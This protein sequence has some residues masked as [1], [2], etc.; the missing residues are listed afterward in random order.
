VA[1]VTPDRAFVL[2]LDPATYRRHALHTDDCAWVEKNCYIDIWIEALHALGCEPLAILPFVVAVDFEG[3]QWT[4]FKPQHAEL[5]EL[6]G[7]GVE[8]LYVW[9]PLID[10]ATEHLGA[11][12]MISTEADAFWLP[13]TAGT[14]YRRQHTKTTIVLNDLDRAQRRLGYFHNANYHVLEGEDFTRTFRLDALP[15]PTFLPLFAEIVRVDRVVRRSPSDLAARSIGLWRR[16]LDRAPSDDPIARF[17]ERTERELPR[18]AEA[19]LDAYH[20]WAFG[21]VRQLGAAFELGAQNLRWLAEQSQGGAAFEE[22][23]RAFSAVSAAAKAFVL[24]AARAVNARRKLDA[25]QLFDAMSSERGAGLAILR[26]HLGGA[27]DGA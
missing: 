6:Y 25:A 24:K 20:A 9:R 17:R 13:D 27:E 23:A 19:G 2:D 21:T 4:F 5:H 11:G 12:K 3:D 16:H 14:D 26:A 22:A 8:E 18:L 10:H 1:V 15:D 7:V